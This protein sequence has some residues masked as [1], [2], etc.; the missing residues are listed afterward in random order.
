MSSAPS[1]HLTSATPQLHWRQQVEHTLPIYHTGPALKTLQF[2]GT[3]A[4]S[5]Q[6][7]LVVFNF[8]VVPAKATEISYKDSRIE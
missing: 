6:Y 7:G 4:G 1:L 2:Q 5:S 3:K 8:G